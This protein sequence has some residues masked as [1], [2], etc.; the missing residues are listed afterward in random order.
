MFTPPTRRLRPLTR[1]DFTPPGQSHP[2]PAPDISNVVLDGDGDSKGITSLHA[3]DNPLRVIGLQDVASTDITCVAWL[4]PTLFD[5][6]RK[7]SGPR[8]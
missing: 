3:H 7:R 2:A 5:G 4:T 1:N 6:R 8:G